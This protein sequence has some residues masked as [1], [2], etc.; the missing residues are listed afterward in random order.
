M[1]LL[2]CPI[3]AACHRATTYDVETMLDTDKHHM[4]R[5]TKYTDRIL[6]AKQASETPFFMDIFLIAGTFEAQESTI[7][8]AEHGTHQL[9]T[10][11]FREQ[12]HLQS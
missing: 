7:F 8:D 1:Q 3:L 4:G 10:R 2:T 6:V 9:W 12:K 5:Y 11:C